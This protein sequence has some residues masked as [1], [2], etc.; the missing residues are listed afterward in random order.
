MDPAGEFLPDLL[1]DRAESKVINLRPG[2]SKWTRETLDQA[3]DFWLYYLRTG[4]S[5]PEKEEY[6]RE[7]SL[8]TIQSVLIQLA[9]R[10]VAGTESYPLADSGFG[11]SQVLPILARG[12]MTS[13]GSTLIVEQPE[14]HLNPALQVRVADF[15]LA[16][17][18]ARKQILIETHSEHIVNAIRAGSAEDESGETATLCRILYLESTGMK[19]TVHELSVLPTGNVPEWPRTFFGEASSLAGRLLRAQRRARHGM[20]TK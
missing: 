18:R 16:M 13:P 17:A 7:L 14:V 4:R 15:L 9:V 12:L 10:T 3:L 11:Y 8:Q 20:D 2:E 1:R 5:N 19:P 6:G